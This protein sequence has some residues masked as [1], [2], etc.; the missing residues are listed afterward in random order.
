MTTDTA[1][2]YR[3]DGV[4]KTVSNYY[5]NADAN[6][7]GNWTNDPTAYQGGAITHIVAYNYLNGDWV[8]ESDTANIYTWWDSA[9]TSIQKY[10]PKVSDWSQNTSTYTYDASGNLSSVAIA[11][12]RPRTVS[13]INT[14]DGLVLQRD[15]ADNQTSGDPR[16]LHYYFDGI[17]VGDVSNNGTS[18]IDYAA[19]IVEHVKTQGSGAFRDGGA[20]V[21]YADF[22]QSYD[23][24]NGLNYQG[25]A[26]H[27]TVQGGDTL[28]SIAQQIWGDSSFWYL[29]ADANGLNGTEDLT[30]G[31]DLIIPNKVGNIHNNTDTFRPYDPNEAL[32]NVSPT[33]PPKHHASPCG[34]FGQ[35][36]MT[37]TSAHTH[38]CSCFVLNSPL[39]IFR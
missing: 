11:D 4:Y 36:L 29:I 19:S 13:F 22:D 2:T 35:I 31:T 39:K 1:W 32:G 34:V 5:Y 16:E 26:S 20:S 10:V 9:E 27:Y 7:D 8:S 15:E 6:A 23:P 14:A 17:Q 18:D 33:A 30:A 25:T 21:S 24:I 12:G 37:I 28:Q 38:S 3:P